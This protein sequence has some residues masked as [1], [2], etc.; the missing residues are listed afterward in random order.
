MRGMFAFAV[1]DAGRKELF[2][3]RDYFG[4]K[5]LYYALIG[6]VFLFGSE[7]KSILEYPGVKREL[8]EEALEQYLSFQYSVLEE[9]FFKGIYR[10]SRGPA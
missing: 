3:A 4:I 8:N 6:N 2:L 9:T 7:I 5:P 10:L 1:W